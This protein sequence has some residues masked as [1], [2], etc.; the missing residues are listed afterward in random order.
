MHFSFIRGTG[1]KVVNK[2]QIKINC[3]RFA[4]TFQNNY[5]ADDTFPQV[6]EDRH[7]QSYSSSIPQTKIRAN[8]GNFPALSIHYSHY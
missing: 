5:S 4:T 7:F 6:M 1:A 3:L 2:I 8:T